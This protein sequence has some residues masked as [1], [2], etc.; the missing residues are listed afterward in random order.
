MRKSQMWWRVAGISLI[1]MLV[2]VG[3]FQGDLDENQP[4]VISENV[5]TETS[6]PSQTPTETLTPTA[7]PTA[8]DSPTPTATFTPDGTLTLDRP[9]G[10]VG[11]QA[12]QPT[13]TD[14]PTPTVT[15]SLTPTPTVTDTPVFSPTPTATETPAAVA[16]VSTPN[17]FQLTATRFVGDATATALAPQTLTAQFLQGQTDEP[18]PDFAATQNAIFIAQTLTAQANQPPPQ[19]QPTQ[20][21]IVQQPTGANCDHQ[22]TRGDNIFRISRYYGVQ[23]ATVLNDN[24]QVTNVN[25]IIAGEKLLIRGCGTTGNPPPPTF[26]PASTSGGGGGGGVVGGPAPSSCN[27]PYVLEPGDTLFSIAAVCNT[28]VSALQTANTIINPNVI[29]AGQQIT[30]PT[31]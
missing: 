1:V 19:Q 20:P 28:S 29:F 27:S 31:G 14:T 7:T 4:N 5:P 25:L 21:T 2:T 8:T 6:A 26:T 22:I 13:E 15:P 12:F 23:I 17:D 3:C 30:I 9:L 10:D 16:Q 18:T 11:A 24:P